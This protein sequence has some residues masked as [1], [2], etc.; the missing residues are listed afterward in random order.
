[1]ELRA[2]W[3]VV[4]RR[5]WVVVALPALVLISYLALRTDVSPSYV[6]GMRFVV[7]VRPEP[8]SEQYTYDRYYTWLT[9]EYL[10]DDLAE[11]VKSQ[12]FARDVADR[13]GLP[14]PPGAIQGATSAGKLHRIL[15]VS[16]SWPDP[17]ELGRLAEAV[18]GVLVDGAGGYFAQ[19]GTEAATVSVIDPPSI[20]V[21]GPSLRQRIDLPLRLALGLGAALGLT[22]LLDY[23]DDSVRDRRDLQTLGLPV[24]A[25]VPPLHSG[26]WWGQGWRRRL[27]GRLRPSWYNGRRLTSGRRH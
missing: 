14:V 4:R 24:L 13:S 22:F 9:A 10:L 7:G 27:V 3:R 5:I 21:V 8:A 18:Q 17:D 6:A 2:Y 1:M 19:L 25:E 11:V 12:R 15:N 26:S 23:V 20:H 16:V